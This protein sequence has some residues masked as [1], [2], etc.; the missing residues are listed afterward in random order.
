[1]VFLRVSLSD[2]VKG[3]FSAVESVDFS[4]F[5]QQL[6]LLPL[7]CFSTEPRVTIE[8]NP[9]LI[10]KAEFHFSFNGLLVIIV[11][12]LIPRKQQ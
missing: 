9:R 1:M 10:P 2:T 8:I 11:V 3:L 4:C 12:L 7:E 6:F 5:S